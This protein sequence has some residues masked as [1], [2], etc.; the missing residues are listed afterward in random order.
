MIGVLANALVP[1]FVGLL[2]GYAAGLRDVVDNRNVK[3]LVTFVMSFAIPCYLYVTVAATPRRLLWNQTKV[4][5]VLAIVYAALFAAT[6]VSSRDTASNRAV[7]ALTLGFPNAAAIGLPLLQSL[8]GEWAGVT[9]A[10][11]IAIGS[12]T[13][14]PVTLVILESETGA[15]KMLSLLARIRLSLWRALKRPI[16][17][18]PL[19]AL[20]AVAT[21]F[22]LPGYFERSLTIFGNA[23]AGT[24]LFMT[25]LVVSAQRF[26][27]TW[28]VVW[29]VCSK[30]LL[31]PALCL[32]VAQVVRLP[33]EEIRYVVLISAIPCGFFG[34][35]F[36]EGFDATPEIASSSLIASYLVGIFTLAGWIVFLNHLP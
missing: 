12:V 28:P 6:Y 16:V 18:A 19:L 23:T 24:A 2:V 34:I 35:F 32:G 1:V 7:L 36:G 29:A 33:R 21:N 9:V 27:F 15:G 30:N 31:Q 3:S 4:A 13:V 11:A 26:T 14:S 20:V 8:Y 17:W 5:L 22:G 25:G 10:I